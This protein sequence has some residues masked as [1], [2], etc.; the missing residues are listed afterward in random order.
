MTVKPCLILLAFGV[1]PV[2]DGRAARIRVNDSGALSRA[3]QRAKPGDEILLAPG[4]YAPGGP[5]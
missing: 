1:F 2:A 5:S 4:R 3:A